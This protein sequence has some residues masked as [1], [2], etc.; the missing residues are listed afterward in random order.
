MPLAAPTT[1]LLEVATLLDARGAQLVVRYLELWKRLLTFEELYRSNFK[2]AIE[3]VAE[4]REQTISPLC[5]EY[6]LQMAG[7]SRAI[8]RLLWR[9][10][11]AGLRVCHY[12]IQKRELDWIGAESIAS[13]VQDASDNYWS[14]QSQ[15]PLSIESLM[16]S[17][18]HVKELCVSRVNPVSEP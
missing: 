11:D 5:E 1:D 13:F 15:I 10:T 2:V 7:N 12:Y 4:L 18:P 17:K 6:C 14:V 16:E 8:C 3:A 9:L